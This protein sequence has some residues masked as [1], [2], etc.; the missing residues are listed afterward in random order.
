MMNQENSQAIINTEHEFEC[1][2][3][4][5]VYPNRNIGKVYIDKKIACEF[6][7]ERGD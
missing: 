6:C 3:C 5:R 1:Y 7:I 4:H 2:S